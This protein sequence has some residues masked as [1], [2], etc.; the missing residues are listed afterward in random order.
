MLRLIKR[1]AIIFAIG[2]ALNIY[3]FTTSIENLR[4]LGVLQRIGIAYILTSICV[5]LLN[6][7]GV[8]S[9]SVV[10]L[11]AYWLLLLSVGSNN[12]YTLENNLDRTVY[13]A[14]LGESHLW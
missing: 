14:V 11:I 7:R 3:P 1:A 4:I 13:I 10:I 12:A 6:R 9:L 5:L 2:L 8:I